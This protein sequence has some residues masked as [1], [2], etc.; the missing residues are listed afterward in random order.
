MYSKVHVATV[1][2]IQNGVLFY[3]VYVMIIYYCTCAHSN[4]KF[5]LQIRQRTKQGPF[6]SFLHLSNTF[7]HFHTFDGSFI[8]RI[9]FEHF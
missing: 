9:V 6:F 3:Y 1:I 5:D 7:Q 2:N 4:H 8:T